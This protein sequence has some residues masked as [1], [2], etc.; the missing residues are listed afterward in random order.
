MWTT[1]NA[2]QPTGFTHAKPYT[3]IHIDLYR[4]IHV[5][6][7]VDPPQCSINARYARLKKNESW[8][9]KG[10]KHFKINVCYLFRLQS[11]SAG[12]LPCIENECCWVAAIAGFVAWVVLD[13]VPVSDHFVAWVHEQN[14]CPAMASWVHKVSALLNWNF[15]SLDCTPIHAAEVTVAERILEIVH[16]VA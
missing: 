3:Q 12:T 13:R 6:I 8:L 16:S 14:L 2:T 11:S 4:S 10:D 5:Y 15:V 7:Y 9:L 1:A